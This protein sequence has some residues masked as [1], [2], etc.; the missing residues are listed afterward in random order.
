MARRLKADPK[1]VRDAADTEPASLIAGSDASSFVA[2]STVSHAND[3]SSVPM[4][5]RRKRRYGPRVY[6]TAI[7][8]FAVSVIMLGGDSLITALFGFPSLAPIATVL[9]ALSLLA[10]VEIR[11]DAQLSAISSVNFEVASSIQGLG[12]DGFRRLFDSTQNLRKEALFIEKSINSQVF[13]IKE[14]LEQINLAAAEAKAATESSQQISKELKADFVQCRK[15]LEKAVAEG[16]NE[17]GGIIGQID[18]VV[19]EGVE[20]LIANGAIA[21]QRLRTAAG[22]AQHSFGIAVESVTSKLEAELR[23]RQAE[24]DRLVGRVPQVTAAFNNATDRIAASIA[25]AAG[26]VE[27][28]FDAFREFFA[29]SAQ[30][31]VSEMDRLSSKTVR[32]LDAGFEK[33]VETLRAEVVRLLETISAGLTDNSRDLSR[34]AEGV[35]AQA[36]NY[37]VTIDRQIDALNRSVDERLEII[38]PLFRDG[39]KFITEAIEQQ[40]R[41]I[42]DATGKSIAGLANGLEKEIAT[43]N[44]AIEAREKDGIAAAEERLKKTISMFNEQYQ[45]I[46]T[47]LGSRMAL[48]ELTIA[49]FAKKYDGMTGEIEEGLGKASRDAMVSIGLHTELI[50]ESVQEQINKVEALL[51]P[52]NENLATLPSD[53]RE[54]VRAIE[55]KAERAEFAIS[56]EADKFAESMNAIADKLV[57]AVQ[58]NVDASEEVMRGRVQALAASLEKILERLYT[59]LELRAGKFSMVM[60]RHAS[61][62]NQSL[63]AAA[64]RRDELKS[65]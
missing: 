12:E 1:S 41:G 42:A 50:L 15:D 34:L 46:E 25:D 37:R 5:T 61:E 27:A 40:A 35:G 33:N 39:A 48:F 7:F 60:S 9:L 11:H 56:K 64:A 29:E 51:G 2:S 4:L 17:L 65:D 18:G 47:N 13:G 59:G 49:D 14:V 52:S 21:E 10:I 32:D 16:R 8:L 3:D 6:R 55:Q 53:L 22:E 26:S 58:T 36:E 45:S 63:S 23:E 30:H 19:E 28:R 43:F 44:L 31:R 38:V 24:L 62:I 20:R 54:V 57:A